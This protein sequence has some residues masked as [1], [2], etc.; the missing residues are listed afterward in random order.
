MAVQCLNVPKNECGGGAADTREEIFGIRVVAAGIAMFYSVLLGDRIL[1]SM[2]FAG[3]KRGAEGDGSGPE[4][5]EHQRSLSSLA[6]DAT[7]A[8]LVEAR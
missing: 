8:A 4:S 1:G 6:G 5:I 2:L 3:T 7:L